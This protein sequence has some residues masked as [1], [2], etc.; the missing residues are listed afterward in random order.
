M[1]GERVVVHN[2]GHG[3]SGM[4]LHWGTAAAACELALEAVRQNSRRAAKL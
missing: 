1:G 3:G 4:T 2:Y